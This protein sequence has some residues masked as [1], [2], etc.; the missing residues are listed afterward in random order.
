M[1]FTH[2]NVESTGSSCD[3]M[4]DYWELVG[5]FNDLPSGKLP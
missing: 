4:G 5:L 2:P 1:G 3:I